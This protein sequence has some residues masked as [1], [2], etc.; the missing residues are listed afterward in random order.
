MKITLAIYEEQPR[1]FKIKLIDFIDFFN[2]LKIFD[3]VWLVTDDTYKE[4]LIT[5][6]A[7]VITQFVYSN[8]PDHLIIQR[9][10]SYEEAYE[11]AL[12]LREPNPKCYAKN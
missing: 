11:V 9:Y 2:D 8:E 7:N 5:E 10:Q 6:S 12:M 3:C 4:I 1:D